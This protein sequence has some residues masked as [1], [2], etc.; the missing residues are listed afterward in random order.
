MLVVITY[1]ADVAIAIAATATTVSK[2]L[3][4][5]GVMPRLP[6]KNFAFLLIVYRPT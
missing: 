1:V 3:L 5:T 6:A 2:R 4:K